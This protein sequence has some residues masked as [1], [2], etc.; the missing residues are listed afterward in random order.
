VI[1]DNQ[2]QAA[3]CWFFKK[4]LRLL[5]VG[6]RGEGEGLIII[7]CKQNLSCVLRDDDDGDDDDLF[8]ELF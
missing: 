1:T 6:G 8:L 3:Y 5:G 4:F 2:Q 7:R